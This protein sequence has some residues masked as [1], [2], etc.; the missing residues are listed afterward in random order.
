MFRRNAAFEESQEE[1]KSSKH[2]NVPYNKSDQTRSQE[3]ISLNQIKGNY[4]K[5]GRAIYTC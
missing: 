3:N 2:S 4:F 1:P 5:N